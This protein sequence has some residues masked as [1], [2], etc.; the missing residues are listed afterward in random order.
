[1]GVNRFKD[2]L[3]LRFGKIISRIVILLINKITLY[4]PINIIKYFPKSLASLFGSSALILDHDK[5]RVFQWADRAARS[6]FV[7]HQKAAFYIKAHF[8]FNNADENEFK[9]FIDKVVFSDSSNKNLLDFYLVWSV[10]YNSQKRHSDLISRVVRKLEASDLRKEID[11]KRYLPEHTTNMGHLGFLFLYAN[12]YRK[13][14]PSR[15]IAIWPDISPNKFYL[16]ELIKILPFKTE[17]ISGNPGELVLQKNQIDTLNYSRVHKGQWRLEAAIDG[18]TMQ[19]FPEFIVN[20]DFMLKSNENFTDYA[21]SQ[22]QRIGFDKNKWF[23][24]LH[25]KEHRFGFGMGGEVRDAAIESY[26]S[27]CE[28]INELGG[29]VVRMGGNNFPKLVNNFPAIDYAHSLIKSEELDYWLWANCKFWVG[30]ANGASVAVIPFRKP[31]LLTNLWPFHASGPPTD[32]CLPKLV[33][34]RST[35]E[36]VPIEQIVSMKLSRNMKKDLFSQSGL[37][38][39]ENPPELLRHATLELYESLNKERSKIV[40]TLESEIYKAMKLSP[41]TPKMRIPQSY[42][43]FLVKMQTTKFLLN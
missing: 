3:E 38:V 33:Y 6:N 30:T 42:N 27:T 34:N 4:T 26:K 7:G 1:M 17:L 35:G 18:P 2:A 37:T 14:D 24:A 31:R 5:N 11:I 21:Q 9:E 23:V 15:C 39:V 32:F 20:D 10:H 25:I 36:L 16:S 43:D 22:L 28:L 8:M 40:S 13:C 29:Q 12:Y 41:I 19:S